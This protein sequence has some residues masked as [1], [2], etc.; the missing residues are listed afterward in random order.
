MTA[1]SA[2]AA[3]GFEREDYYCALESTLVCE[4]EDR[5]LFKR[6][7]ASYFSPQEASNKPEGR[8]S[9]EADDEYSDIAMKKTF[10][11]VDSIKEFS[12]HKSK[13]ERINKMANVPLAVLLAKAIGENDYQALHY[14]AE[15][16]V[17]S[18]GKLQREDVYRIDELVDKAER[19][20]GW[21][22]VVEKLMPI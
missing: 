9:G 16:G 13:D 22:G 12:E 20:I 11:K 19:S 18:L 5:P 7:F 10:A 4:Q 6:L 2:V 15:L 14:L 3:V 8:G 17:K 1:L 21:Y